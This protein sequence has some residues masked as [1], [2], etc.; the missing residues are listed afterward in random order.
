MKT[1]DH[2]A[3]APGV[4]AALTELEDSIR[5]RY[6]SATFSI[7]QGFGDDPEGIYLFATVDLEDLT[8]VVDIYSDRLVDMQVEEGLPVHVIPVRP[9]ERIAAMLDERQT[10]ANGGRSLA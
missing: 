7:S 6:P 9:P 5:H 10:H 4:R 3:A 2:V 8:A 1:E